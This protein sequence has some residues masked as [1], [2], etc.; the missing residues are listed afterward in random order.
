M[1]QQRNTVQ[2]SLVLQAVQ[3]MHNHPTAEQIYSALASQHPSISR[4]TVY[5]NLGILAASGDIQRVSHLNAA[6][7]FDF[8]CTPHYHFRC[9][10]CDEVFDLEAPY[11]E[12]LHKELQDQGDFLVESCDIVFTG[13]CPDCQK[14]K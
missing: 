5:R 11:R 6:D 8:N 10:G 7:R 9:R 12:E 14:K 2:R 1:P 3:C 13:L 4:A